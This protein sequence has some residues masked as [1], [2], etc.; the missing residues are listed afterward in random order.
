MLNTS[1]QAAPAIFDLPLTIAPWHSDNKTA[2]P[3]YL[4][5]AVLLTEYIMLSLN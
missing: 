3:K 4:E 2:I 5:I 1:R